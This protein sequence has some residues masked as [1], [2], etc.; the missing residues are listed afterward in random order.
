MS[1]KAD[2]PNPEVFS[3]K[4]DLLTDE[5]LA[6]RRK[7]ELDDDITDPIDTLEGRF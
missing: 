7:A 4:I 3:T 6:A 5:E 1:S 2:N